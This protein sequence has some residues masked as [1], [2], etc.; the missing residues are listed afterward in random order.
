MSETRPCRYP[1][2]Q[3]RDGNPRPTQHGIC[4]TTDQHGHIT[5]GCQTRFLRDIRNLTLDW[6]ALRTQLPEPIHTQQPRRTT[7]R[8]YGHPAEWASDTAAHIAGQLNDIHDNL[9]EILN[10]TPPPHPG[11]TE[12][13][14]V[15]AAWK[16]LEPRIQD[17]A[18]QE[19]AADTATEIRQLHGRIRSRLG[20]SNPT[21][22]LPI[23]C[24]NNECGLRTLHRRIRPGT[25]FIT[26][27]NCGYTV[28]DDLDGNNYRWL[29]R[30]CLDTLLTTA[31]TQN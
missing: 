5:G 6:V 3:D 4:I 20:R 11:T 13:V 29:V 21:E 27:G 15:R 10:T 25:D 30:V 18:N 7:N 16:F 23:P 31:E 12:L 28:K 1:G 8:E 22:T 9:A 17:L 19:W 26:C 2:C 24:P 14:R